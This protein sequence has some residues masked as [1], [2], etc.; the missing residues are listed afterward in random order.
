MHDASS[1]DPAHPDPGPAIDAA[2]PSDTG[3]RLR[4]RRLDLGLR[5]VEVA[6]GAGISAS[7]LALIESGRR[8]IGGRVLLRLA[9]VLGTDAAALTGAGRAALLG[10]LR[11]AAAAFPEA[12]AEDG[13]EA[14]RAPDLASRF[15]GW[16]A[17]V[18]RQAARI[19]T[20]ERTVATLSDRMTHDPFLSA[21]VHEMLSAVSAI[22]SSAAILTGEDAVDPVWQRRVLGNIDGDAR[23]LAEASEGLAAYLD[24]APERDSATATPADELE[25]VLEADPD[26][27]RAIE[28]GRD[29]P[30]ALAAAPGL[31]PAGRDLALRFARRLRADAL[32]LP[33]ADLAPGADPLEVADRHGLTFDAVL[34]RIA[35]VERGTGLVIADGSGTITF[36]ARTPGFE[37]PRFGAACPLWPLFQA[38]AQPGM[39]LRRTVVQPGDAPPFEAFAV[40]RPV[41][42]ARYGAPATHEA[43]MLLRPA[44][45]DATDPDPV[46]VSCRICPRAGCAVRREPSI[47]GTPEPRR[48]AF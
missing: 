1:A 31:G 18:L 15:P 35:A 10:D 30:E 37:L 33:R 6:R 45:P 11:A 40:A 42:P 36:R 19:E 47:L 38:L 14:A 34:R 25:A 48:D 20:L 17:L 28:E 5:Q 39:P 7:Y 13:A 24:A 8:R 2:A 32:A 26:R 29:P 27:L 21:S 43:T 3:A 46:G 4:A 12:F 44:P 23:R 22:R 16:T 41:G 9:Q